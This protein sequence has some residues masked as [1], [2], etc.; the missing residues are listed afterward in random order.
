MSFIIK[1]PQ[2]VFDGGDNGDKEREL[3]GERVDPEQGRIA[4]SSRKCQY[5]RVLKCMLLCHPA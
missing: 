4:S 3:S 1:S 5:E 2:P